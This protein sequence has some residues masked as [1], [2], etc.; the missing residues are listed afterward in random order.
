MV[1][2]IDRT[3]SIEVCRETYDRLQ[4]KAVPFEDTPDDVI[5]SLLNESNG[6]VDRVP[7][8]GSNLTGNGGVAES[9]HEAPKGNLEV[10]IVVSDAMSPPSLKHTRVLRA[11]VDGR[12]VLKANWTNVRQTVV[13]IAL[14]QFGG[15]LR[16]VLEICPMN[17]LEGVKE[18]EGYTYYPDFGAS[19]QGSGCQPCVAGGGGFCRI[20]GHLGESLVPVEDEAGR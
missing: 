5:T 3:V 14:L 8:L 13:S 19:I 7:S 11:E 17:A 15:S 20:F 2:T 10:D 12:E 9:T 18:D 16:R 6:M 1:K 4:Q